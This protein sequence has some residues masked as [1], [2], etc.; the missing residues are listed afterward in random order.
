LGA[1]G[2]PAGGT[3]NTYSLTQEFTGASYL[4]AHFGAYETDGLNLLPLSRQRTFV[5]SD[6]VYSPNADFPLLAKNNSGSDQYY[7]GNLYVPAGGVVGHPVESTT[8]LIRFTSPYSGNVSVTVSLEDAES[9]SPNGVS[10]G[11]VQMP[12]GLLF[13]G[14]VPDGGSVSQTQPT[15]VSTGD[16]IDLTIQNAGNYN[17]DGTRIV[18]TITEL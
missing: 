7:G 18:F 9:G 2:T 13:G 12:G 8:L 10:Y 16:F 4:T 15:T 5:G 17:G 11:V 1:T 3:K 14:T 6:A